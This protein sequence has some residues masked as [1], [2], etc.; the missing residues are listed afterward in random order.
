MA[1]NAFRLLPEEEEC[2]KRWTA[3][4]WAN[5]RKGWIFITSTETTRTVQLP[6]ISMWLD[7]ILLRLMTKPAPGTTTTP[8]WLIID[9][10]A[11]LHR[12][13]SLQ[14]ALTRARK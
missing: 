12:L 4:E 9:E 14:P 3:R 11:S 10:L 7:T 6:L 1:L 2:T 8:V 13:P 5:T